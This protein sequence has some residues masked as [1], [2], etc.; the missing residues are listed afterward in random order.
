[1]SAGFIVA[2]V[3]YRWNRRKQRLRQIVLSATLRRNFGLAA[4]LLAAPKGEAP[5]REIDTCCLLA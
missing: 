5:S 3:M 1:M 4:P 2:I